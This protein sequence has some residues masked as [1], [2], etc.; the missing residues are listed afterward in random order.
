MTAKLLTLSGILICGFCTM[1]AAPPNVVMII[2]DDQSWGDYGFMGHPVI[3]TPHLD[4]LATESLV[5]THGYVSMSL[6][7]PSLATLITGLYPHQSKIAT[8]YAWNHPTGVPLDERPFNGSREGKYWRLHQEMIHFIRQVPT[9]PR[10]LAG[11]GYKSWQGGKW[12]EG[13]YSNGGFSSGMTLGTPDND[14]SKTGARNWRGGDRG[15]ALGREDGLKPVFDFI[16]EV[17]GER[18][19]VWYAPLLPHGPHTPPERLLQ[20]YESQT[21][22]IRVARYWA[23]CEWF[24]ETVGELLDYLD[25]NDLANNT[26]VMFVGDN[27]YIPL[28]DAGGP[29]YTRSKGSAY[30][31]GIRTPIMLRWP[32]HIKASRDD[33]TLVSSIDLAPTILAACDLQATEEMPGLNLLDTDAVEG[34]EAIFGAIFTHVARDLQEPA[35]SLK[36]RWGISGRWKLIVPSATN[37]PEAR[38]ELYNLEVDP[39]EERNLAATHPD[40]VKRLQTTI[41]S[42]WPAN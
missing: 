3:R 8:N 5:Y 16:S 19:F 26:L 37:V 17:K 33:S 24:D 10:L 1:M 12:W 38:V 36:Y 2:G 11:R 28:T 27:G 29:D 41:D 4:R 20:K 42:W 21:D 40:R 30:D 15:L 9:L 14:S 6:C 22:S 18:F 39:A 35:S 25:Q 31:A 34:R 23:M 32:G 7:R 13:H